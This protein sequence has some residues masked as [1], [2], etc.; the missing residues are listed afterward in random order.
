MAVSMGS[1][2]AAKGKKVTLPMIVRGAAAEGFELTGVPECEP[3]ELKATLGRDEKAKGT[4]VRYL[5]SLEYPAGSPPAT[6]RENNPAKVRFRTNQP[7][8]EEIELSVWL[9]A[10]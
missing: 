1:F 7:G 8:A 10:F 4:Q 9:S 5:L 2:D 6:R 3:R